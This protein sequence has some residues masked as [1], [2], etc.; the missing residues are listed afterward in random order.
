MELTTCKQLDSA[1]GHLEWD[2]GLGG[3]SNAL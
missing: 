1:C 3:Q 2:I